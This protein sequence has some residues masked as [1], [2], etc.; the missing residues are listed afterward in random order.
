MALALWLNSN[1]VDGNMTE[2]ET[3]VQQ[4]MGSALLDTNRMAAEA[5]RV[6]NYASAGV[7]TAQTQLDTLQAA[8]ADMLTASDWEAVHAARPVVAEQ[9]ANLTLAELAEHAD[10]VANGT[11]KVLQYVY[12]RHLE[13]A[14]STP[15]SGPQRLYN[16]LATGLP[17]HAPVGT[18]AA[19]RAAL[20]AVSAR[21]AAR[22]L[23]HFDTDSLQKAQAAAQ[24]DVTANRKLKIRAGRALSKLG[25]VQAASTLNRY[26]DV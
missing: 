25:V 9:L 8:P 13:A 12:L 6:S 1:T 17:A 22:L 21:L 7:D 16:G 11:D 3:A 18:L 19:D 20:H 14:L 15:D 4:N 26:T 2:I 5:E 24:A 10:K 23:G